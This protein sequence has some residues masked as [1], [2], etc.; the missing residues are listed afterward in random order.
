[1][2]RKFLKDESGATV[3]EHALT[4]LLFTVALIAAFDAIVWS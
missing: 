1:M 2:M 4:A 3:V